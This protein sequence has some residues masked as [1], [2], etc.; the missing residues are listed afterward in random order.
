MTPFASIMNGLDTPT[1]ADVQLGPETASEALEFLGIDS[2]AEKDAVDHQDTRQ[3]MHHIFAK[4]HNEIGSL[5]E[6]MSLLTKEVRALRSEVALL[7]LATDSTPIMGVDPDEDDPSDGYCKPQSLFCFCIEKLEEPSKLRCFEGLRTLILLFF[8]SIAQFTLAF[9]FFDAT[10]LTAAATS[11]YPAFSN[12]VS[13]THLY[14]SHNVQLDENDGPVPIVN[15]LSSIIAMFLLAAIPL[16]DDSVETYLTAQPMD[17]LI[18]RAASRRT[19]SDVLQDVLFAFSMQLTWTIRALALHPAAAM[20]TAFAMASADTAVDIVLNSVAIGTRR[21]RSVSL[22]RV[23]CFLLTRGPGCG[24]VSPIISLSSNAKKVHSLSCPSYSGT[25]VSWF[26][27]SSNASSDV[28]CPSSAGKFVSLFL[29]SHNFLS[30]V[31]S[32]IHA[33]TLES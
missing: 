29:T 8:L 1:R 18:F 2:A 4:Q 14:A 27:V 20:G 24:S 32:P 7:R 30:E 28:S 5:R 21:H 19:C 9:S 13:L 15:A 17:R 6:D 31:S 23:Q 10:W 16:R 11:N 33:G 22:G 25:F 12:A 26:L 3:E